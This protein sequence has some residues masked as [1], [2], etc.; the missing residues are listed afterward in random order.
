MET[1]VQETAAHCHMESEQDGCVDDEMMDPLHSNISKENIPRVGMEF[2]SE[3]AAYEFYNTY[4]LMVGFSVRKSSAHRYRGTVLDRIYVCSC[5]GKRGPDK[6]DNIYKSHRAETRCGC[7]AR[8]KISCRQVGKFRVI[9]FVA[10]HN[11]DLAS[12]GNIH[13][14]R[15]HRKMSTSHASEFDMADRPDIPPRNAYVFMAKQ[16]AGCE[17]RFAGVENRNYL[18]GK[19]SIEMKSGDTCVVLAY[20]QAMQVQDPSFFYAIQVDEDDLITN[21][22]WADATMMTDY[23]DFGDVICFD[24]TYR[25]NKDGRPIVLF[26]GVNHHKQSTIFGVALMYDGTSESFAWLFDTFSRA[27]GGKAPKTMFIEEDDVILKALAFQ[28]PETYQRLCIRHIFQNATIQLSDV[29]ARY[30][31]FSRDFSNCIYDYEHE[32]EF[33][34]AWTELLDKYELKNNDWL[35]KMFNIKEKW[36]LVYGRDRFGADMATTQRG[37]SMDEF[38]KHYVSYEHDLEI[39]LEKFQQL[40]SDRRYDEMVADIKASQGEVVWSLPIAILK[41]A[42]SVYTFEV[43]QLFKDELCK[44]YDSPLEV[45]GEMGTVIKYKVTPHKKHYSY[46]VSFDAM[47]EIV[48]C[49]CMKFEFSGLLCSHILKVFYFR[50]IT[51]VPSKYILKRWTK[52]AKRGISVNLDGDPKSTMGRSYRDLCRLST[53]LITRAAESEDGYN[54]V[55]EGFLNLLRKL[56]LSG[57]MRSKRPKHSS[58]CNSNSPCLAGNHVE[59]QIVPSHI[60]Q[61]NQKFQLD[62]SVP[63]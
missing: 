27:M 40:L 9:D 57:P 13:L 51:E 58:S 37:E 63:Q 35:K 47:Q 38:I 4:A 20:L 24:T 56:D 10:K 49:N 7:L 50:V 2:E 45:C 55:K 25:K 53:R 36:A 5:Q 39:F 60:A 23:E 16:A 15:S 21:I 61:E 18:Q 44:G 62:R 43:F 12:P 32:E 11:H 3:D 33:V 52:N 1:T 34:N 48:S 31:E 46:V 54:L 8:L 41:H 6:R 19:R 28:W 42:A 22:F 17:T 59:Q 29:F 14:F 30:E 26:V